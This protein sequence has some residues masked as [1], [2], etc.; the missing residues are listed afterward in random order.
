MTLPV[1]MNIST[2]V[3][4]KI[5]REFGTTLLF[6]LLLLPDSTHLLFVI[7]PNRESNRNLDSFVIIPP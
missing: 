1:A 7:E 5:E 4:R 3:A 2:V 6:N